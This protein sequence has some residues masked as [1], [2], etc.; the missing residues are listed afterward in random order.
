VNMLIIGGLA[1]VVLAALLGV[2]LLSMGEE[3][4]EKEQQAQEKAVALPVQPS[5][6]VPQTPPVA[7][8]EQLTHSTGKLMPLQKE[9]T[10]GDVNNQLYEVT[11]ALLMLAQRIG[12]LDLRLNDLAT[13][14]ERRESPG[15]TEVTEITD[16]HVH[17]PDINR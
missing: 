9:V 4:A 10:L 13:T 16:H 3:R 8:A 6:P 15:V 14:L 7:E 5:Q 11:D 1:V 17:V 2:V 12:E